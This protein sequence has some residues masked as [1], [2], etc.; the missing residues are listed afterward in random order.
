MLKP[1]CKRYLRMFIVK[2]EVCLYNGAIK[3]ILDNWGN[4]NLDY[5]FDN[6]IVRMFNFQV[7]D[8][9]IMSMQESV[10]ALKIHKEVTQ[11]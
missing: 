7:C 1:F 10:L 5:I 11:G 8:V 3:G 6:I 4:L 9:G 2:I